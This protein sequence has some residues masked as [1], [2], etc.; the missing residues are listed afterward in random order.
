MLWGTT[1]AGIIS[2]PDKYYFGPEV[3]GV[4][5]HTLIGVPFTY[6]VMV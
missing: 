6:Q 3:G 5:P 1:T 2:L 4:E